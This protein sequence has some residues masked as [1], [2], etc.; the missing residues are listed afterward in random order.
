MKK[1]M[2]D[3]GM[4]TDEKI[5][6]VENNIPGLPAGE[7]DISVRHDLE[8]T[9]SRDGDDAIGES[10]IATKR[11]VVRGERFTLDAGDIVTPFPPANNQGEYG[12]VLPHLICSRR[13]LPWERSPGGEKG[14]PWL[15]L[16]V[17]RESDP[18]PALATVQVGDL[19]RDEFHRSKEARDA[20]GA[21]SPSTLPAAAV[22]YGDAMLKSGRNFELDHGENYFDSCQ[23]I[24]IGVDLFSSIVPSLGDLGWLAHARTVPTTDKPGEERAKPAEYSVLIANRLPA[25]NARCAVH[26]VSLEHLAPWLPS[27]DEYAPAAITL[28]D[29]GK[30][31]T[32]RLV[33]LMNWSFTS[34]DPQQTFDG[35]LEHLGTGA[36]RITATKH[37]DAPG[38]NYVRDAFAMGYT[39]INHHTRQGDRTV[40]WYRGPFLPFRAPTGSTLS[41]SD[42]TPPDEPVDFADQ[43]VR[44]NPETGMM[45]I[46]YASAWQ[47]GRLLGLQNREFSIALYD[48]KR[49]NARTTARALE[50]NII[51]EQFGDMLAAVPEESSVGTARSDL[52]RAGIEFVRTTLGP[53]LVSMSSGEDKE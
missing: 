30:A 9:R 2:E 50:R 41:P 31:S 14:T 25:P 27:N 28:P 51:A 7:Y 16:L 47:M 12:H 46:S 53:H 1:P 34:V 8:N 23:V 13:T 49:S 24:D 40:S 3:D 19:G 42:P 20:G 4:P 18:I 43:L 22:S 6:F 5:I 35:I 44:Y 21:K 32:I 11:F 52:Y 15:A 17:F 38:E 48:W 29:G 36:L 45:D 26:L 33:S 39:A 37:S 10:Y